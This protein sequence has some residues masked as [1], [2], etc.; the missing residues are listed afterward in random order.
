TG[1]PAGAG[2]PVLVG[3]V[4]PLSGPFSL[5]GRQLRD[6]ALDAIAAASIE[7]RPVIADDRCSAEGGAAAGELLAGQGVVAVIGFLC[8][9]AMEAAMPPLA[10]ASIPVLTPGVRAT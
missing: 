7:F 6:G 10:D 9:E 1:V 8:G 3:V 5:L 4:A 2:E